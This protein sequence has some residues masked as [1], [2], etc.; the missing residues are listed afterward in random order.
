MFTE[1]L[2]NFGLSEKEA[3]AYLALLEL[4]VATAHEVADKAELNRS[5]TYVVLESLQ[6]RGLTSISGGEKIKKYVVVPP[7]QLARIAQQTANEKLQI[8][9]S[10]EHLLPDLKLLYGG[11]KKRPHV[12]IFEGKAGFVNSFEETLEMKEK[13]I[14]IVSST[15]KIQNTLP[16]YLPSYVKRRMELGIA[17]H[18]IHPYTEQADYLRKNV[19]HIDDA[20]LISPEKWHFMSDFAV[21]DN[22]VG[23]MLHDELISIHIDSPTIADAMKKIFDLAFEEAKRLNIEKSSV[24]PSKEEAP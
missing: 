24:K 11:N 15:D 21:F 20:Q 7:E 16:E 1:E 23:F 5:S 19:T 14:R 13:V 9:K 3:R 22:T 10:I 2:V 18:G 12:R 6:A 8:Q 17:M 4:E